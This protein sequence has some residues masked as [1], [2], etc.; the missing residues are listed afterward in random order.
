MNDLTNNNLLAAMQSW[1]PAPEVTIE[2]RVYYD[3]SGCTFKTTEQPN[4][5]FVV[6]TRDEYDAIA[7]CP[8][9]YV[10][11]LGKIVKKQVDFAYR[12]LLELSDTG[13]ATIRNNNIFIVDKEYV[14]EVD[15][16]SLR[17]LNE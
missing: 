14:G 1:V 12:K 8:D 2:Y 6:V 15:H 5:E 17:I 4:G 9:Y 3:T 16:W 7:F 10:S 11:K 13:Y